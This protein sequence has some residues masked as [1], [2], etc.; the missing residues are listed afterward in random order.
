[1][2]SAR[3]ARPAHPTA[4][5][6]TP[7]KILVTGGAGFIGSHLCEALLADGHHLVVLDDFNDYYPPA[8]KHAHLAPIRDQLDALV[9]ADIRDPAAIERTFATHHPIH[10]VYHLAARAGVR[11]SIHSPRLYLST[12]IDG[13]LNLL[14]ACRAH[15]VPDFILA[16]SSSVYGANP[17]TPFAETDPI[18]RT[19]SPYAASKLA[20]EQ[21]C[22]NYAH[23]HGLRCLCLRLFTVYGP[24]QRPDLAIARFTAA[25]RDGRPIDLYGDGTTAR[26]YTYVDDIIQGLLA[27]GRRTA[28]LPP[29]TFEIFNLGESATTTLNELVTLIENALGRPALIRRQPEQPGDVP[30]TYA[31][32]SKARR[33]L[34]YAPATLP[35]DG[36]RKYIRWLETNQPAPASLQIG[37]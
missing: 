18:Q 17:K 14:E 28:T 33:L 31:D 8:L 11:P 19:L 36:I 2:T 25:I 16:S 35:A 22:S 34:G 24:R 7:Q 5:P 21:L 20:A 27:A 29:A 10:A 12:N 15:H 1:M 6:R 37:R 4:P 26:D 32:I 23:L 9:Q 13:T 30:R 3:P